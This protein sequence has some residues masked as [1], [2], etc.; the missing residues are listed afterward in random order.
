[1]EML[2]SN[3]CSDIYTKV[4]IEVK[5]LENNDL[6]GKMVLSNAGR[7]FNHLYV[8]IGQ[9]DSQYVLLSNGSTKTIEKP[10][11]K[12]LKHLSI[13]EAVDE[14][15]RNAIINKEKSTDL[16]VKRFLKLKGIV[17]EG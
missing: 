4:I 1:M 14:D 2:L 16:K 11:K 12:K 5:Y 8:L 9:I 13:I 3:K 6:I 10:K 15:L 7:D 17:K